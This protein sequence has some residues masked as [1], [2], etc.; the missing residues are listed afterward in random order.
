MTNHFDKSRRRENLENKSKFKKLKRSGFSRHGDPIQSR[1]ND[2]K[3]AE[4][5]KLREI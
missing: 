1:C 5:R 2:W 3:C 4:F